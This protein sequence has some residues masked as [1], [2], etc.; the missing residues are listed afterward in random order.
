MPAGGHVVRI[1]A[2]DLTG[3]ADTAGA[4]AARGWA[5]EVALEPG[6]VR[7]AAVAAWTAES[8]CLPG[9]AAA[10]AVASGCGLLAARAPAPDGAHV[11]HFL[12]IDS[13]LRGD[14][15]RAV[16]AALGAWG[17]EEAWVAPAF[18]AQGRR[19]VGGVQWVAAPA[20]GPGTA[21]SLGT[22]LRRLFAGIP[23][24]I[25][26][27][28]GDGDLDRLVQEGIQREG[29]ARV[30]WVGAAGLAAALARGLPAHAPAAGGESRA[31]GRGAR[32]ASAVLVVCGSR[33]PAA[34]AQA[35][36][37]AA[38]AAVVRAGDADIRDLAAALADGRDGL[39]LP[40]AADADAGLVAA[41]L[42]RTA[43]AV[44]DRAAAQRRTGSYGLVLTGGDTASAVLRSL[45]V[46]R[47]QLTGELEPGV[48]Q[49]IAWPGGHMVVTK[50]G[51]FGADDALLRAVR[52]LRALSGTG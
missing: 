1:V 33:H 32:G 47:L 50:A 9:P 28:A 21:A 24:R 29:M 39:L 10:A 11:L 19:T 7:P 12:K 35:Q 44:L 26:D 14:P 37:L 18:P 15:P 31:A 36:R 42:G 2:D 48:P 51:G 16:R 49:A 25:G 4:F 34:R 27:A 52:A 5:A 43:R 46:G 45:G 6:G 30:L 13:T 3:A 20:A 17:L 8:R 23:C 41:S 22:D 38:Y 40:P